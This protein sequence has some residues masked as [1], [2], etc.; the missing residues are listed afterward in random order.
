MPGMHIESLRIAREQGEA[1]NLTDRK[2]RRT[3]PIPM[4]R[5]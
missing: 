5:I 1:I 3:A 2:H 4:R